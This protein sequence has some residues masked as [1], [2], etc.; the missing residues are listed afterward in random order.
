[1]NR[2]AI[3]W[4]KTY[5]LDDVACPASNCY[6]DC[7]KCETQCSDF[8]AIEVAIEALEKQ[9]PK[10]P[11]EISNRKYCPRCYENKEYFPVNNWSFGININELHEDE[12]RRTTHCKHC[13]QAIDW[14]DE[15]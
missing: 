8:M 4:L 3:Y 2:G 1:M 10:K 15:E 12:V 6:E 5:T 9:I 11:Q 13:G 14:S 7:Q